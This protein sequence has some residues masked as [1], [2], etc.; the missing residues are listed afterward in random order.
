MS[1][2]ATASL[3]QTSTHFM[4]KTSLRELVKTSAACMIGLLVRETE[5]LVT[6][7][8]VNL[9]LCL[10]NYRPMNAYWGVELCSHWHWMEMSGQIHTPAATPLVH[11]EG[12]GGQ[13]ITDSRWPVRDS[14]RTPFQI[15]V[16]RVTSTL[17]CT[18]QTTRW[19]IFVNKPEIEPTFANV[20][21][22]K[23]F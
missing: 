23:I 14:N 18:C 12:R 8:K 16:M 9:I 1:L 21:K 4:K 13:Q 6:Q 15:R 3:S 2:P 22:S 7:V 20:C 17:G 11:S 10:I 19:I 5:L